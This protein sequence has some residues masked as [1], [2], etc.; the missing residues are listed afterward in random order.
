MIYFSNTTSIFHDNLRGLG[1]GGGDISHIVSSH[2]DLSKN[3][4]TSSIVFDRNLSRQDGVGG[5]HSVLMQNYCEKVAS[6]KG[7]A[8]QV[9]L[10]LK[11]SN[12]GSNI[13]LSGIQSSYYSA[14]NRSR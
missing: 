12:S 8:S 10:P 6:G 11:N 14:A 5:A 13:A 7:L 1:G 4:S 3:H 9:S 2:D